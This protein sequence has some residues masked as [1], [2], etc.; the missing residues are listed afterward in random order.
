MQDKLNDTLSY[1][2]IQFKLKRCQPCQFFLIMDEN[3]NILLLK[4]LEMPP[5]LCISETKYLE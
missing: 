5:E 3:F 1:Y 4:K 2:N